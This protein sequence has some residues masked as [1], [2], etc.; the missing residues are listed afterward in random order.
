MHVFSPFLQSHHVPHVDR[1]RLGRR[2]ETFF[3]LAEQT[4]L[5]KT[6]LEFSLAE[7]VAAIVEQRR[8]RRLVGRREVG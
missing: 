8:R 3:S 5:G 4:Q 6:E 1:R 7:Q 2:M